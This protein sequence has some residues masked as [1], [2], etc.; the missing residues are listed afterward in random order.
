MPSIMQEHEI[1]VRLAHQSHSANPC[2]LTSAG[3]DI[4][5]CLASPEPSRLSPT[6]S[7]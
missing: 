7:L 5:L 4:L 3:D 2:D 1:A 6:T